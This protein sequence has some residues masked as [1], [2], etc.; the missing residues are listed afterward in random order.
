MSIYSSD[1]KIDPKERLLHRLAYKLEM[2]CR[3]HY[4]NFFVKLE[5][6]FKKAQNPGTKKDIK[7]P[8]K[9]IAGA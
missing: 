2:K 3:K 7:N 5:N 8:V 1:T 9:M 6:M 4:Y